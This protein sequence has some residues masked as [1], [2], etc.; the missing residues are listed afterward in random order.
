MEISL[1]GRSAIVTGGSKG[2]GLAV[3]TRFAQSGGDVAIVARGKEALDE[4]LGAIKKTAKGVSSEC[5]P[6]SARRRIS[7]VPMTR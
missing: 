5:R 6:T 3:A 2:I 4:A 7:S 1:L